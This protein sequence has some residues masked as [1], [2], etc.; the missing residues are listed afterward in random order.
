MRVV[1]FIGKIY[2]AVIRDRVGR[3]ALNFGK[4]LILASILVASERF[5][6]WILSLSLP[7]N[8]PAWQIIDPVSKAVL[9]GGAVL[10]TLCTA[11]EVALAFIMS[12]VDSIRKPFSG[13]DGKD[14]T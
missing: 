13:E 9:I 6:H 1:G 14:E 5:L 11:L 4:A 10:S 8:D 3:A 12:L 7:P 2:R